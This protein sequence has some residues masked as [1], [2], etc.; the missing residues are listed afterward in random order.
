MRLKRFEFGIAKGNW[1]VDLV[2]GYCGCLLFD[3][4]PFYV[5]LLGD[6]CLDAIK[7]SQ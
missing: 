1:R 2:R 7:S 3:L 6:E 4:G 5:T